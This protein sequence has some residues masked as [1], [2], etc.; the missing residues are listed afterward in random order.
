MKWMPRKPMKS[1]CSGMDEKLASLLLDPAGASEK[2]H[3]HLAGCESCR[4]ELEE[5]RATMNLMDAWEIPEPNPYFLTRL[6]ARLRGEREAGPAGW[7]AALRAR[8]AYGPA[9][10]VRPLAAM[11]LTVVLLVGGGTYLG[12]TDWNQPPVASGQASV[13]H[14]L[15][16]MDNNAQLLDQLEAISSNNNQDG[17]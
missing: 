5:L 16:T 1:N 10:N 12:V 13:V 4:R 15:Q 3:K 7:L 8:F 17:D 14:D 2:V 9:A 6:E 11:A